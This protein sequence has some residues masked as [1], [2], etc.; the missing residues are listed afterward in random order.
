MQALIIE[1]SDIHA[2]VAERLF[3]RAGI[4][5]RRARSF[6]EGIEAA[7]ALLEAPEGPATLI[8]FDVM[9]PHE[10]C[11]A[12]EGTTCAAYLGEC[13]ERGMLRPAYMAAFSSEMD[14]QR[15]AE[16]LAAGCVDV[17]QKP[18]AEAHVRRWAA[19]LQST[20]AL[21]AASPEQ[22][23]LRATLRRSAQQLLHF[24]RSEASYRF[25]FEEMSVWDQESVRRLL[26]APT[27]VIGAEP[28]REWLRRRGG[29]EAVR[30]WLQELRMPED[31]QTMLRM[32][33]V[34]GDQWR[35]TAD[36]L[37][38][39]RTTYYRHL[40]QLSSDLAVELNSWVG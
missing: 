35:R 8:L 29:V 7:F 15:R 37:H 33:L 10:R 21:P 39:S 5:T 18:L 38:L 11:P 17:V 20:P 25:A 36:E 2:F 9:L 34:N 19:L 16:A 6:S 4:A 1:D 14:D 31:Q 23:A 24:L 28:W 26:V 30:M 32:V 13:M 22:R 3:G 40:D 27:T 12:L